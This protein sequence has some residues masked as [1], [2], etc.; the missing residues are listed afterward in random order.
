MNGS[1][2]NGVLRFVPRLRSDPW[3]LNRVI[4]AQEFTKKVFPGLQFV[5][6]NTHFPFGKKGSKE[7]SHVH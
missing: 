1:I 3:N 4:P 2:R 6:E 5:L 7:S